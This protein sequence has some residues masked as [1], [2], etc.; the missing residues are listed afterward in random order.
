MKKIKNEIFTIP[1][2]LSFTRLF[3]VPIIVWEYYSGRYTHTA[4]WIV[5]SGITDI[6][7]G[8]IAR[9]FNFTNF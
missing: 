2:I 5:A 1:N 4:I 3:M 8:F 9:K 7:D 6:V